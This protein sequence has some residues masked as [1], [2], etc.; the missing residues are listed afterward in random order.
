MTTQLPP[1]TWYVS[2]STTEV[3]LTATKLGLFTVPAE[4]AVDAGQI[5]VGAGNTITSVELSIDAGTY[6]SAN[7]KRNEHVVG[8]DFLDAT[9]Y[10]KITFRSSDVTA[11]DD[12]YRASGE[13]T[14]KGKASPMTVDVANVRVKGDLATFTATAAVDRNAIGITATPSFIVAPT[15]QLSASVATTTAKPAPKPEASARLQ[16]FEKEIAGL[17]VKGSDAE[18]ERK[19][20]ALGVVAT[21]AGLIVTVIGLLGVR[22]G[23]SGLAQTDSMA[24][25]LLGVTIALIG[26]VLWARYSVGRYLRYWMVREIIEQRSQTDRL[27]EAIE[28]GDNITVSD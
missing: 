16:N 1:G 8:A 10:P 6:S 14:I 12:G 3:T 26:V 23:D 28:R 27:I 15:L 24:L 21:I 11:V 13:I 22:S 18:P 5:E 4:F 25:L 20:L 19:L 9:A 7:P 2:P 17:G